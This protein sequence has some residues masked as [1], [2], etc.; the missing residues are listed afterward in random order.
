MAG[1]AWAQRRTLSTCNLQQDPTVPLAPRARTVEAQ[2]AIA[3]PLEEAEGG[4]YAV[5]GFAFPAE[6]ELTDELLTRCERAA[7]TLYRALPER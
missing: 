5:I 3:I 4:V 6:I 7:E 1:Q 2:H